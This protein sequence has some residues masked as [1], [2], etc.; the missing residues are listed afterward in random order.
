MFIVNHPKIYAA[1]ILSFEF[2]Y[3]W[4]TKGCSPVKEVPEEERAQSTPTLCSPKKHLTRQWMVMKSLIHLLVPVLFTW[5]YCCIL[6]P[7]QQITIYVHYL[8]K[9]AVPFVFWL[10]LTQTSVYC[11]LNFRAG[12]DSACHMIITRTSSLLPDVTSSLQHRQP[13]AI[14]EGLNILQMLF[15]LQFFT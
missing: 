15:E 3:F 9:S 10:F 11:W 5:T 12:Q 1:V 7:P 8:S 14:R 6:F 2:L 13:Y 4:F